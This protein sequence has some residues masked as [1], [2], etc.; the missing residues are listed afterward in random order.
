MNTSKALKAITLI[1]LMAGAYLLSEWVMPSDIKH[2]TTA[3]FIQSQGKLFYVIIIGVL[4]GIPMGVW[5]SR[6]RKSHTSASKKIK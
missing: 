2:I 5:S 6:T 1:S 4:V 3:S